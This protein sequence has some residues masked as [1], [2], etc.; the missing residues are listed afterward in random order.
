MG[1]I[2]SKTLIETWS[3]KTIS[4][5]ML[6]YTSVDICDCYYGMAC[7][8]SKTDLLFKKKNLYQTAVGNAM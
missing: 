1:K 2:Q 8:V 6:L 7:T 4:L 3:K 5:L